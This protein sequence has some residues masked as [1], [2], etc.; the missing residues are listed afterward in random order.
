MPQKIEDS[1]LEKY[2]IRFCHERMDNGELRFRLI[3]GDGS[4]YIR[5]ENASESFVWENSHSHSAL[6]EMIIVQ[7]GELVFAQYENGRASFRL[8]RAGDYAVTCPHIPHNDGLSART[9]VHTVKFGETENGD[10]LPSPELDALTK[11]LSEE[12]AKA[13]AALD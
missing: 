3:S 10:W 1:E 2:G 4:S 11:P 8:L 6:R 13:A 9:V 5:C 7:R 12:S